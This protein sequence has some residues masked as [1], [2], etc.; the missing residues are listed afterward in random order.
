M[1]NQHEVRAENVDLKRLGAVLSV[2]YER[3]LHD[4]AELLLLEKLGPLTLSDRYWKC[5][6][7]R[8]GHDRDHNV[9][10]N[11]RD[12]G[13]RVLLAVGHTERLNACGASV[14]P[15]TAGRSR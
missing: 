6:A 13:I 3:D 11:I 8:A 1:P 14:R 15:A 7:C 2:A 4:F 10:K 9:A 12:E 5:P